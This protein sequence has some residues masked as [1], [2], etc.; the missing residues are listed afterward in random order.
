MDDVTEIAHDVDVLVIGGG[1]AGLSA[2][3][4][5]QR[6]AMNAV[7]V[8]AEAGPGGAWRHRWASLRMA[9]VNGIFD[10]PGFPQ[11]DA[12][13]P[14]ERS[15]VA[16]PR[17]FAAFEERYGLGVVRPV[18]VT[19]VSA[20]DA[21]PT[22]RLLVQSE[23]GNWSARAIINATGT[24]TKPYIP[25]YPG[26]E[27]FLGRQ[28][29]AAAYTQAKDLAGL[30]VAVV[31]G[32]ITAVQLLAEISEV[33]NTMWFT[34][35]EPVWIDQFDHETVGRQTIS[36]VEA[37]VQRGLPVK[38][39]VSY[40]G[41]VRTADIADAQQRGALQRRA[42]FTRIEPQGVRTVD[43]QILPADVIVWA[44]GFRAALDH[45]APLGIDPIQGIVMNGT[46]VASDPRIHLIGYGP[47][48]S[49]VG[50]NRAGRQAVQAIRRRLNG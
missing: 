28:F 17:Y 23:R 32:G 25:V 11:T 4:H 47:S 30:R 5:L 49:T 22:G 21:A 27:S 9:T 1:Q 29:H 50:A 31:G 41:L 7:I 36:K 15:S 26:A 16:V 35:R 19:A 48:Q 12:P 37:D 46:A 2:A 24:W 34:R 13:D 33:A 42:M 14:Q 45:L 10:L 3:Y 38:S 18:V 6:Q 20:V 44:T 43:G 40:T 8:D 39:I